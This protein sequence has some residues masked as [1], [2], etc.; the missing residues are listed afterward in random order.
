MNIYGTF[1]AV[2][3]RRMRRNDFLRRLVRGAGFIAEALVFPG[4]VGGGKNPHSESGLDARRRA[5]DRGSAPVGGGAVSEKPRSRDGPFSFD[6]AA[7]QDAGRT[8]SAQS[9]G[10]GAPGRP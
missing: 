6:R 9:Q 3:M 7:S 5:G 4:V 1:P 2:R 10:L 8:C